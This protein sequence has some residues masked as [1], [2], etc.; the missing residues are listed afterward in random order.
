MDKSEKFLEYRN[1]IFSIAY[2]MLGS[3]E[4]AE[5]I[6]NEVYLKW[7]SIDSG[8]I[9]Q[10]K[11]YLVKTVTNMSINYLKTARKKREEY[12]GL[13]LPESIEKEYAAKPDAP[14]EIYYS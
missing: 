12:S 5:D 6:I 10:V 14:V 7:M 1:L 2:D 9:K 4:D 13:W 8:E 11:A 3:V